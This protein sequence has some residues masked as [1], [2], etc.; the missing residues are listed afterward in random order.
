MGANQVKSEEAS[1]SADMEKSVST[2]KKDVPSVQEASQADDGQSDISNQPV[3]KIS[4][5]ETVS[6][7]TVN[8]NLANI[9]AYS[10]GDIIA[11]GSYEQDGDSANG[12]ESIEWE[13]L[14]M[15]Q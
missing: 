3:D 5:N 4:E 9:S 11:L 6:V 2:E 7:G 10:R 15:D 14:A 1:E 12:P 8:D 13:V